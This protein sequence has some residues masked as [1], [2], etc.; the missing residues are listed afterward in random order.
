MNDEGIPGILIGRYP[1][2]K[3]AGGNPWQLLTAILAEC[4]YQAAEQTI[5]SFAMDNNKNGKLNDLQNSPWIKLFFEDPTKGK[6]N[7]FLGLSLTI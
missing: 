2:D 5:E 7:T 1:G 4:F 6:L 3:Y